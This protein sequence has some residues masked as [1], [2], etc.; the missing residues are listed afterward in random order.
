MTDRQLLKLAAKVAGIP[1]RWDSVRGIYRR[2]DVADDYNFN[3]WNPFK[4]DADTF[5]LLVRMSDE[6]KGAADPHAAA[7]RMIVE[8]V[9]KEGGK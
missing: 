3:E 1:I 5:D 4:Y 6:F 8:M 7:R 2:L 9:V